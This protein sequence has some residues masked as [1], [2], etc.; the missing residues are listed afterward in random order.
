MK[1]K[2]AS[3]VISP[4][5]LAAKVIADQYAVQQKIFSYLNDF[6]KG[7]H[8]KLYQRVDTE[9]VLASVYGDLAAHFAELEAAATGGK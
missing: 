1:K 9:A 6:A 7:E 5:A 8:L 2:T 3:S 4:L